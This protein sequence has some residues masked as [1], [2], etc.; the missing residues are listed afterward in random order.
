[1][2]HLGAFKEQLPA[3][4]GRSVLSYGTARAFRTE[5]TPPAKD[6][7]TVY[8]II[9]P[10]H[11]VINYRCGVIARASS[12]CTASDL[13]CERAA[14]PV[15]A[16]PTH[17]EDGWLSFRYLPLPTTWEDGCLTRSG[18][19]QRRF[20]WTPQQAGEAARFPTAL[21]PVNVRQLAI[22][23]RDGEARSTRSR[24]RPR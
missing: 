4:L 1:M 17:G 9:L 14:C 11:L 15:P 16:T 3:T 13:G 7:N 24:K 2:S 12:L 10:S 5:G 21:P 6:M 8:D 20:A 22:A 19:T 23:L 18:G